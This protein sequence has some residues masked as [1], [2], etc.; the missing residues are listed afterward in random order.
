MWSPYWPILGVHVVADYAQLQLESGQRKPG[1]DVSPSKSAAHPNDYGFG[2]AATRTSRARN[3]NTRHTT[4][5]I[6]PTHPSRASM[7]GHSVSICKNS[8]MIQVTASRV[9]MWTRCKRT[10]MWRCSAAETRRQRQD[11]AYCRTR[12]PWSVPGHYNANVAP[13]RSLPILCF[14]HRMPACEGRG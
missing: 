4:I 14:G 13:D 6:P 8:A 7:L 9:R 2:D 10:P 1:V 3:G 12:D 5:R 11:V